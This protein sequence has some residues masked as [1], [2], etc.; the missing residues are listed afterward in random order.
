MKL[1]ADNGA[2]VP[3]KVKDNHDGTYV[4]EF[5]PEAVVPITADVKYADKPVPKSP[6]KIS[7]EPA[8]GRKPDASK[9]KLLGPAVEGPVKCCEPTYFV[10]DAKEAGPGVFLKRF[11]LNK[12]CL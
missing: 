1:V 10:V 2:P 5:V 9:V 11:C 12:N 8:T 3:A 4:V 6:L 7:V